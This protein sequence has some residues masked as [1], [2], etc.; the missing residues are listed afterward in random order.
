[1][2]KPRIEIQ[3][4][5]LV[6]HGFSPAQRYAIGDF[7][8]L[9]LERLLL[10]GDLSF[11]ENMDIPVIRSSVIK[12]NPESKPDMVGAQVAQALLGSLPNQDRKA[13]L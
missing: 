12:I 6:L 10:D 11:H 4:D 13:G 1:M 9:E 7:L 5:E 2:I 3:I 8:A